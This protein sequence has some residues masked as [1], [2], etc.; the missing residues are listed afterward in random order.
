MKEMKESEFKNIVYSLLN[1]KDL[2][3]EVKAPI[4]DFNLIKY[5][6]YDKTLLFYVD[7]E[8]INKSWFNDEIEWIWSAIC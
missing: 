5:D 8:K 7:L 4:V 2:N 3:I 1:I 6:A